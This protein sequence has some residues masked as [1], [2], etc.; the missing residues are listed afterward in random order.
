MEGGRMTDWQW[1]YNG[2]TWGDGTSIDVVKVTGLDLPDVR[3]ADAPRGGNHGNH[4]GPDLA[5]GRSITFELEVSDTAGAAFET[6]L[7]TLRAAT[8]VRQE[9]MPLVGQIAGQTA[10]RIMCRPRRR[11]FGV[12]LPYSLGLG[13]VLLQLDASD[14]IIYAATGG[15]G[16]TG[17]PAG[18]TGRTYSRTYPRVYGSAGTGGLVS[19]DN[20]GDFDVPWRA[21]ITGPWVNPTILHVATGRQLTINVTL[22][23]GETLTVDSQDH[24][25]LLSG[26]ASR[27]SSL[28]QPATWFDLTPGTNEIRFG[29]ASG[30]GT[31]VLSWR[32]GWL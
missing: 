28:V 25:I 3:T 16:S 21:E 14:P 6:T 17:F 10:R 7:A 9:E 22:N 23:S 5:A 18:G 26:S 31:A 11:A 2:A 4:P 24:S 27:Y 1:T 13:T 8:V 32:S 19:A 20:D 12:D 29:G 30:S 15:T